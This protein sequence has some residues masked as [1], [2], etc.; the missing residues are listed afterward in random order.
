MMMM[1][2]RLPLPAARAAVQIGAMMGGAHTLSQ[3]V[4]AWIETQ[5][6]P[7]YTRKYVDSLS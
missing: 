4:A 2:E 1:V 5:S 6:P 7:S 3:Y